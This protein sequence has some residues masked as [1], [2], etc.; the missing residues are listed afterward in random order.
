MSEE[1]PVKLHFF[2]VNMKDKFIALCKR[3]DITSH[4]QKLQDDSYNVTT[5]PLKP[6]QRRSLISKWGEVSVERIG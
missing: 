5:Q 4:V 3:E 2:D 6:T 1:R